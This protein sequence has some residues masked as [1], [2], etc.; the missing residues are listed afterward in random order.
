MKTQIQKHVQMIAVIA[1]TVFTLNVAL[2]D[3][4]NPPTYRGDPLSVFAHWQLDPTGTNALVLNPADP[5]QYDW[6]DDSDPATFLDPLPVSAVVTGPDYQFDLPNFVDDLPIKYMRLQVTW[7]NDPTPL[8]IVGLSA[9][10]PTGTVTSS[11]VFSSPVLTVDPAAAIYYQYHDIEFKPNPDFERWVI[12]SPNA[13]IIQ[14]VADTVSTVPEPAT[15]SLIAL[16]SL[17][18]LRK[19]K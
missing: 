2:A 13:P 12:I 7:L 11:V 10:D 8:P 3:D 9:F 4:L 6:V 17:A 19:R 14:V 15:L 18:F 16:G 1:I 5:T